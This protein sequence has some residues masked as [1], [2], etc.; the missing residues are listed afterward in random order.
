ML[1]RCG[2]GSGLEDSR[3]GWI[4][5]DHED[6]IISQGS[7]IASQISSPL[8]AEAMAMREA[9]LQSSNRNHRKLR[10]ASDSQ[11]L[12]KLIN[13]DNYQ[14]EIYGIIRDIFKLS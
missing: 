8:M 12:T 2:V 4:S 9:L 11:Q 1:L 7:K 3:L 13:S 5:R 6:K 14:L 10:M